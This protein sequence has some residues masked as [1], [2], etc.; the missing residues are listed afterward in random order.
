MPSQLRALSPLPAPRNLGAAGPSSLKGAGATQ[1]RAEPWRD[2]VIQPWLQ[3]V[4][5]IFGFPLDSRLIKEVIPIT[6]IIFFIKPP[7]SPYMQ[8]CVQGLLLKLPCQG[9]ALEDTLTGQDAM[10]LHSLAGDK[11]LD[12]SCKLLRPRLGPKAWSRIWTVYHLQNI[13]DAAGHA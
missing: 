13:Y 12:T 1:N 3:T 4:Q 10:N 5:Q 11:R 2:F 8:R 7:L 6:T 9:T